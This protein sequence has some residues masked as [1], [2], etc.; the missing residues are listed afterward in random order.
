MSMLSIDGVPI[1]EIE[2][3]E[4]IHLRQ[5]AQ[6]KPGRLRGRIIISVSPPDRNVAPYRPQTV[7]VR[8][9]ERW[10]AMLEIQFENSS[11]REERMP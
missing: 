3:H 7:I 4:A 10:T 5:L 9:T 1:A 8:T 11:E 2:E 6:Q